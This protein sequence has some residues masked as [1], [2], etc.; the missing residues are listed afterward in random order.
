MLFFSSYNLFAEETL[1][2]GT[3]LRREPS[4]LNAL[5]LEKKPVRSSLVPRFSVNIAPAESKMREYAK[6]ASW[7]RS[8]S[9]QLRKTLAQAESDNERRI[10]GNKLSSV[11]SGAIDVLAREDGAK[12]YYQA[13]LLVDGNGFFKN[14]S[15][16]VSLFNR[17]MANG[18]GEKDTYLYRAYALYDLKRYT[19]SLSDFYKAV[20]N[21]RHDKHLYYHIGMCLFLQKKYADAADYFS[22]NLALDDGYA[23]SYYYRGLSYFR[24]GQFDKAVSDYDTAVFLDKSLAKPY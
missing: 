5:I 24:L 15:K 17:A 19:E 13:L 22:K 14:P 10:I 12:S 7:Q 2:G 6:K 21:G 16:A 8:L 11:N 20:K 23:E 18:G 1:Y 4:G 3:D 9:A